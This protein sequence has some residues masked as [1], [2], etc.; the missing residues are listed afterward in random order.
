MRP[1]AA[2]CVALACQPLGGLPRPPER[3]IPVQRAWAISESSLNGQAR[4]KDLVCHERETSQDSG[5][6]ACA[7]TPPRCRA[8]KRPTLP[9]SFGPHSWR[10]PRPATRVALSS[11]RR[12]IALRR[13]PT[14]IILPR[15]SGFK[16]YKQAAASYVVASRDAHR[17]T[18]TM[19]YVCSVSPNHAALYGT[20]QNT[21]KPNRSS[22]LHGCGLSAGST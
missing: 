1:F 5:R 10:G 21:T 12:Y 20:V 18:R 22:S 9:C 14:I 13:E 17:H 8:P 3:F 15:T 19:I 4:Q 7:L 16:R 2:L 6:I 11:T